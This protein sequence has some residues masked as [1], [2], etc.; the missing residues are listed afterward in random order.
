MIEISN[1]YKMY[2]YSNDD[3]IQPMPSRFE[4]A[5]N[6]KREHFQN[7]LHKESNGVKVIQAV[8]NLF[9]DRRLVKCGV[10]ECECET[11]NHNH[12]KDRVFEDV[13]LNHSPD[14]G[15]EARAAYTEGSAAH[16]A[17]LAAI[18]AFGWPEFIFT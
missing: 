3:R 1:F 14:G 9:L 2:T 4:V 11:G 18:V 5:F 10:F 15:P 7:Q 6:A 8:N 16:E 17:T 13:V 12:R